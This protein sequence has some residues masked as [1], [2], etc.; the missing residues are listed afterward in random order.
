MNLYSNK[1]KWKVALL[2]IAL[3]LIAISLWISNDIVKKVGDQ[4]RQRAQQWAI[5]IKKRI[6]LV[7]LTDRIFTQL[8][9]KEREKMS[10]WVEASKEV[11]S[12]SG[13]SVPDFPMQIVKNND[14][15][16][17]ILLDDHNN[18]AGH[19]NISLQLDD[20]KIEYPHLSEIECK[21]LFEDSLHK[22]ADMWKEKNPAFT[23]EVYPKMFMTYVYDDSKVIAQ[24]EV[25]RDSL[26]QAFNRELIDNEGLVPVLLIDQQM[27]TIIGTNIDRQILEKDNLATVIDN[28]ARNNDSIIIDFNNATRNVLYFNSSIALK[29][30]YYFPYIQ[31]LIIGLFIFIGYLLFSTFRKA[32]QNQVWAGMA[33]ET[34]HQL[35]TPISSLMA[36]TQLLETQPTTP[37]ILAEMHKDILRLEKVSDRFSKIGSRSTIKQANLSNTIVETIDYL[38]LRIAPQIDLQANIPPDIHCLHSPSLISWVVENIIKNA[39]DAMNGKGTLSIVLKRDNK[40]THIEIIDT[41]KGMNAK[42]MR[43]IFKPGYTT[44]KRGWGL[45]LSLSHRIVEEYH[46]GKISVTSQL[47]VGST[48]KISLPN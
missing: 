7:Q 23:V 39:I 6:E 12:S 9:E 30:L 29:Q 11:A 21:Q 25:E 44:K 33:K 32:E 19:R 20:L 16:P 14:N 27:R 35:G 48:F 15:I 41:G 3:L 24:L 42:Q 4:E 10:L 37:A 2:F 38:Q 8:R 46:N 5:A 40:W 26:F 31:F 1:Q 18:I 43:V 28:M 13:F 47:H 34:A 22:L 17:V 45:G 36:W